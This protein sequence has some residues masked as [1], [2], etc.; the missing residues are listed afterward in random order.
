MSV[1][2]VEIEISVQAYEQQTKDGRWRFI[3]LRF[4]SAQSHLG[5]VIATCQELGITNIGYSYAF[6]S[7]WSPHSDPKQIAHLAVGYSPVNSRA[8]QTLKKATSGARSAV[9]RTM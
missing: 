4:N 9:S 7:R 2:A 1:A 3:P 8:E 5:L 6:F